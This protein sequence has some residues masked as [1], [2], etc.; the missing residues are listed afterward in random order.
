M[1]FREE[2]N[3]ITDGYEKV[4][5]WNFNISSSRKHPI[6]QIW[7][8]RLQLAE[9]KNGNCN[10]TEEELY[11]KWFPD[12]IHNV[13]PIEFYLAITWYKPRDIVRFIS[14]CQN[15]LANNEESFFN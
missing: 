13:E 9:E 2:L 14:A 8:K 3:K 6:F 15:C 1:D 4:L 7:L 10:L 11:K 5:S 12:R